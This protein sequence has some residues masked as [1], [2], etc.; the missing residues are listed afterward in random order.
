MWMDDVA[1][2]WNGRMKQVDTAAS[3]SRDGGGSEPGAGEKGDSA[4]VGAA[5]EAMKREKQEG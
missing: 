3:C 4:Q 1:G 5:D 2:P